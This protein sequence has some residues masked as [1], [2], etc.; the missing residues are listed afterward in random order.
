M[1]LLTSSNHSNASA[2]SRHGMTN[3][4]VDLL[5]RLTAHELRD[6]AD[7]DVDIA[8]GLG[9]E[10]VT[11]GL[12]MG[13]VLALWTAPFR[14]DVDRVVAIAPAIS[15]PPVPSLVATA[16]NNLFSRVPNLSLPSPSKLDHAYHGES[17]GALAAM[18]LLPQQ[19][20][21]SSY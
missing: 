7:D 18:F 14:P 2:R 17:T 13:G 9:D 20:K 19:P 3:R 21:S 4:S 8:Q 1:P 11:S 15:I 16:F 6:F 10:V 5:G 12:S